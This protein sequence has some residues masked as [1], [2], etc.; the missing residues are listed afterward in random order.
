M[1]AIKKQSQAFLTN[2]YFF[3]KRTGRPAGGRPILTTFIPMKNTLIAYCW[4]FAIKDAPDG[5]TNDSFGAA[6]PGIHPFGSVHVAVDAIDGSV[7]IYLVPSAFRL[8][9]VWDGIEDWRILVTN[10]IPENPGVFL[11]RN[12]QIVLFYEDGINTIET[13]RH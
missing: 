12:F 7:V 3:Y 9:R 6:E 1:H 2:Q 11:V 4:H 5:V 8:R 13:H 10:M